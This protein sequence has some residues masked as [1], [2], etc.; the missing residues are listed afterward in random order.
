MAEQEC[1]H[2]E[3]HRNVKGHNGP[4]HV[5]CPREKPGNVKVYG[6]QETGLP[7][8]IRQATTAGQKTGEQKNI[9]YAKI[10]GRGEPHATGPE[11]R[12]EPA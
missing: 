3:P 11:D 9:R 2:Q 6:P 7:A 12:E 1:G 4:G 10:T 5:T 8:M